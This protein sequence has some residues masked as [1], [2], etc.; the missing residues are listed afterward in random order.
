MYT[1]VMV[2]IFKFTNLQLRSLSTGKGTNA[3]FLQRKDY[4]KSNFIDMFIRILCFS[5]FLNI[6]WVLCSVFSL[7]FFKLKIL[8]CN[9]YI[10]QI[11]NKYIHMSW[12]IGVRL[13]H[14]TKCCSTIC[15]NA[16][17]NVEAS[18]CSIIYDMIF[19]INYCL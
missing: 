10:E 2:F 12:K 14:L 7:Y 18:Y 15:E 11:I 3:V 1:N 9:R 8:T 6:F 4:Q 17:I 16:D 5:N 19:V 13:E